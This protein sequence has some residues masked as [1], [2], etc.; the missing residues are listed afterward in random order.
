[1]NR[2]RKEIVVVD[3]ILLPSNTMAILNFLNQNGLLI[4]TN[5]LYFPYKATDGNIPPFIISTK[6]LDPSLQTVAVNGYLSL[7]AL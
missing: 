6:R 7:R 3:A 4:V 5:F 2:K 1:V